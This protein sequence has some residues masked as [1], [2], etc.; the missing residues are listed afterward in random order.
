MHWVG[1]IIKWFEIGYHIFYLKTKTEFDWIMN[2]VREKNIA[3]L[4][5]KKSYWIVNGT[6]I[7]DFD[8]HHV[9]ISSQ[10]I[11]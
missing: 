8:N 10:Q 5:S 4:Q 3:I 7:K 2:K 6:F 11:K 1:S 9:I